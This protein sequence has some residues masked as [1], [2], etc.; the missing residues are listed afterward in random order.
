MKAILLL[1]TSVPKVFVLI[2]QVQRF[3]RSRDHVIMKVL[4]T[5][6]NIF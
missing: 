2:T 4:L 5:V 6:I 1:K 3:E